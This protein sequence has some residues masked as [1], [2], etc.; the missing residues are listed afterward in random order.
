MPAASTIDLTGH[1]LIAMPAMADPNFARTVTYLCE[2]N[3]RGALGIVINRPTEL[4]LQGLFEQVDIPLEAPGLRELPVHYG[5]PVQVD[6]GFVLHSPLGQWQSTLKVTETIGLTT[7]RDILTALGQGDGPAQVLVTIGYA[8]WAPGQL[9]Q[10]IRQNAWL[11]VQAE[12]PL[13]FEHPP[14]QR[15]AAALRLLGVDL[16]RLSEQAGHA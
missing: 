2:H 8:G 15:H 3:S 1:C 11:T 16:S 10:E 4:T 6:R 14:A 5:G 13:L 12:A 9:E 7:S